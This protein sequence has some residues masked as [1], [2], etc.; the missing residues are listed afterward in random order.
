MRT[1]PPALDEPGRRAVVTP[2]RRPPVRQSV[3]VRA[4]QRRTFEVF[5][6]TEYAPRGRT[7]PGI[8][9][10]P[11][12]DARYAAAVRATTT[13]DLS[14]EEIHQLGLKQVARLEVGTRQDRLHPEHRA[15][16]G[17]PPGHGVEHGHHRHEGVAPVGDTGTDRAGRQAS[18]PVTFRKWMSGC[19][20]VKSGIM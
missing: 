5:V 11:E 20:R 10:L 9:A 1:M 17:R 15:G 14:P 12:G 7:E 8:W 6:R 16:E 18:H 4:P 19:H 2:L 3:V 13:T